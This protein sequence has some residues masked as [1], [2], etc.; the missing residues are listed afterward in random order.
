MGIEFGDIQP[1]VL[2]FIEDENI[3]FNDSEWHQV[4]TAHERYDF[5]WLAF[6]YML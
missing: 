2:P 4:I 6:H 3:D 5:D 1:I